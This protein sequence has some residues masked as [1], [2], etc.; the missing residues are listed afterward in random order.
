MIRVS[1]SSLVAIRTRECM[2]Q[3]QTKRFYHGRYLF[4]ATKRVAS[5]ALYFIVLFCS[6]LGELCR[7]EH[8]SKFFNI[9]VAPCAALHQPIMGLRTDYDSCRPQPILQAQ[10]RNRRRTVRSF[11]PEAATEESI[12]DHH[13]ILER[14]DRKEKSHGR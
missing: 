13:Q 6:V 10:W 14:E 12:G 4:T 11:N 9:L 5:R 2:V 1:L 7:A 3:R 8:Y